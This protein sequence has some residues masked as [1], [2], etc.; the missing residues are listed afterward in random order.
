MIQLRD[1]SV[2][3][4]GFTL[5]E[6]NLT[7]EKGEFFTLLGPTGAGKTLILESIS[8][9]IP[10][11]RGT[12][13]INGKDVSKMPPERRGVGIV[14]Q[15]SALFPHL[16]VRKNIFFGLRYHGKTVRQSGKALDA[17]IEWFSLE[18]LLDRS[19]VNLSGGE[20]QRVALITALLLRRDI[21]LLDE[22]TSALDR[23]SKKAALDYLASLRD[24]TLI[25]VTHDAA[26]S[27]AA[28]RVIQLA[29]NS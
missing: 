17:I 15:D 8:G 18:H 1:L 5:K 2:K 14:Y 4:P 24:I 12:I 22:A 10:I 6:I 29:Q 20:K 9:M 11:H 28:D 7:V 27:D 19:V 23:E 16:N 3:L 21:Y 26:V 25:S 13:T